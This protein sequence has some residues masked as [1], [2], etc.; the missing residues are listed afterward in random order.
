MKLLKL[1][2]VKR[3][4]DPSIPQHRLA[5]VLLLLSAYRELGNDGETV[6]LF[7][8]L[9]QLG[10]EPELAVAFGFPNGVPSERWVVLAH[11]KLV[12]NWDRL[13]AVLP[14][15]VFKPARV[16]DMHSDRSGLIGRIEKLKAYGLEHAV[17]R[18]FPRAV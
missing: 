12:D 14:W 7:P 4:R 11:R 6:Q 9:D 18:M 15:R 3:R 16:L 2:P 5:V 10:S 8:L 17:E 1:I 13:Q